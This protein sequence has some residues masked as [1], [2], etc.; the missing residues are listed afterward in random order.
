MKLEILGNSGFKSGDRP[1]KMVKMIP[2]NQ[3]DQELIRE[4]NINCLV[5]LM[6]VNQFRQIESAR[7]SV[8]PVS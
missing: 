5:D 3:A 4:L 1:L 6:I 7:I 2:E 8:L